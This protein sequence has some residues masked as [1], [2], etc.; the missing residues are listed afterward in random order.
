M[1][2]TESREMYPGNPHTWL[3]DGRL[4]RLLDPND[5]TNRKL[6][7]VNFHLLKMYTHKITCQNKF[8][9]NVVE[10]LSPIILGPT[11]VEFKRQLK[12]FC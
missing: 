2:L 3:C 4:L 8:N 12:H 5:P 9:S 11:I 7:Q 1:T 10:G 6:F